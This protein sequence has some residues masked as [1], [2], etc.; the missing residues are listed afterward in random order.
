VSD[1]RVEEF[2]AWQRASRCDRHSL[3]RP[4]LRCLLD[5]LRRLGVL[6]AEEPAAA[7][8]PTD[9]L[10]AGFERYLL[11]ER[12]LAAGTVVLYQASAR[13]FVDGL[14]LDC[15]LA[16]LA[17]GDVTTAVLRESG[18]VSV[19]AAQNFVSGVRSFLRFCFIEGLV[20]QTSRGRP[21]SRDGV[22]ARR[23]RGGSAGPTLAHCS[24]PVIGATRSD[25]ETTRSSSSC[26]GWGCVAAR[27]QA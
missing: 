27:W 17:A 2:L 25:G 14:S 22:R 23:C 6:A 24:V 26:C 1:V 13:R 5:V 19:S 8:S 10:L 7:S 12:G 20:G 15:G 3:S 21:C 11:A 4:G 9:V 18:V 16:G